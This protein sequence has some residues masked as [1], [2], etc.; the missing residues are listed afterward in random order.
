MYAQQYYKFSEVQL[1]PREEMLSKCFLP[2]LQVWE[3][4][5]VACIYE[6]LVNS[7]YRII[8]KCAPFL[9]QL[10][11]DAI[12]GCLGPSGLKGRQYNPIFYAYLLFSMI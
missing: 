7:Y 1:Q 6:Y 2:A 9:D 8:G 12:Y 5:E 4:E 3:S 11:S 10:E